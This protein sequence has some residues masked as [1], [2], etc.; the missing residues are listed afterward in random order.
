MS[1]G[2]AELA[3]FTGGVETPN[4]RGLRIDRADLSAD[5]DAADAANPHTEA[6]AS[7]MR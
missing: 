1:I 7:S 5:R 6:I 2:G 3:S 4:H